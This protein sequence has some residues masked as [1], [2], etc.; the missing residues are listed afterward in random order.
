MYGVTVGEWLHSV[1]A[2]D[3][4]LHYSA[5]GA[6]ETTFLVLLVVGGGDNETGLFSHTR[7]N[8]DALKI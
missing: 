5:H 7:M 6:E 4:G 8:L 3:G 2:R 1:L